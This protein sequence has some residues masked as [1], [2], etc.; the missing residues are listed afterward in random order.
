MEAS[1]CGRIQRCFVSGCE[2]SKGHFNTRTVLCVTER[3]VEALWWRGRYG[4][5]WLLEHIEEEDQAINHLILRQ[6][7]R[8]QYTASNVS[9]GSDLKC[10]QCHT[11]LNI[12]SNTCRY[13]EIHPSV[14]TN[15]T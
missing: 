4:N 1:H 15:E 7:R 9:C 6:E 12:I 3:E 14:L 5:V 13:F 10:S 8:V 11:R 2:R